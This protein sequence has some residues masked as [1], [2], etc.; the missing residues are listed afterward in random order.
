[1]RK[2]WFAFTAVVVLSFAVL[3]W[4]GFRIYQEAPPVPTRVVTADGRQVIGP[5]EIYGGQNVWQ[6]IGG[7]E[8]GSDLGP[9]QLRGAGLDGGLASSRGH[10]HSRPLE[11]FGRRVCG[12]AD[13]ATGA[14]QS[15]L[16]QLMRTNTYDASS[17]TL[18]V[19]PVR[20]AAFDANVAHY[21]DVFTRGRD[22]YA[23]PPGALTD[24]D[25]LRKLSAFF[26]WTAWAASTNRPND[27]IT[28]TSNWPHEPL[29]GNRP[30][31]DTIVWTG[32]SIIVLLAGIGVMASYYASIREHGLPAEAPANDPVLGVGGHTVAA[33]RRQVLLGRLGVDP[34]ADSAGYRRR[35]L[36]RRRE[37]VLWDSDRAVPARTRSR[38]R[39]TSSSASSGSRRPGWPPVSSSVRR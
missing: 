15:R 19:D 14:L 3:G 36:R 37:C 32:V 26:F 25:N 24:T 17:G 28:Y 10:V 8:V 11:R 1:M 18:T 13:G 27:T 22:E 4:T 2:L 29:V 31:A 21:S 35:P 34:R 23:I 9:W 5:D 20:A 16:Q 6:S 7:M 33:C 38:A 39:G 30:T 12:V